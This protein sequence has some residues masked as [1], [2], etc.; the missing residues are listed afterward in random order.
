MNE[1]RG[2]LGHVNKYLDLQPEHF[3]EQLDALESEVERLAASPFET[4]PA[5]WRAV[6]EARLALG[7]ATVAAAHAAMLHC[8]ARGYVTTERRPAPAARSLLRGNRHARHQAAQEDARRH[9]ELI[10]KS[11]CALRQAARHDRERHGHQTESRRSSTL[12][13]RSSS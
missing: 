3:A 1:V 4:D 2:P 13:T 8:G 12:E 6:I 10:S 11:E 7:E 9:G 5:Y